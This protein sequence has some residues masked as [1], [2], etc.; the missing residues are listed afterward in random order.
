M[1]TI[2]ATP[3]SG[4]VSH[5]SSVVAEVQ[6]A[7]GH[8][9]SLLQK[10]PSSNRSSLGNVPI[11]DFAPS[12]SDSVESRRVV[13]QHIRKASSEIGFFYIINHGISASTCEG[14]LKL[15][16]RFFKELPRDKKEELHIKYSPLFRG[17][18]PSE[19]S[20]PNLKS[21]ASQGKAM[22]ENKEAFNW[23]YQEELDPTGGDGKYVELDGDRKAGNVW[24]KEED[25]PGFFEGIKDYYGK[26]G[27]FFGF[28]RFRKLGYVTETGL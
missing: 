23:G 13:A 9:Q 10:R 19:L 6:E 16:E 7:Q 17:W 5:G 15:A 8:L 3:N 11:I 12:F 18:R 4:T 21:D 27:K 26:V 1:T 2:L 25:L 14:V 20:D 24:P 22:V 28:H